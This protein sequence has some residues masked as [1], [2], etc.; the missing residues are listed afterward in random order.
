MN[1][2][3]LGSPKVLFFH[4]LTVPKGW[5]THMKGTQV[6]RDSHQSEKESQGRPGDSTKLPEDK[7]MPNLSLSPTPHLGQSYSVQNGLKTCV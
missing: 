7:L 4:H 3:I 5:G 2:Y 6:C 1:D